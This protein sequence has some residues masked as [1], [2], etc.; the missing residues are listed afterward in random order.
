MA[1][2]TLSFTIEG[3]KQLSRTLLMIADRVKDWTPAFEQAAMDLK[4]IF[5]TEVFE[6]QGA[7]IE[8][9]W[10]G[11]SPNYAAQ[12][13]KRY[14]GRGVLEASGTMRNSFMS[15]VRPDMLGIWNKAEYF[16]YHQSNRPRTKIPRRVM[17]KL[18]NAQKELVVKIFHTYFQQAIVP[19][20]L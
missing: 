16:K 6:T 1:G 18:A 5:S 4:T 19:Q 13:A 3:E 10:Q 2:L 9:H 7:V 8:E 11:L 15:L 14:P 17:I 12:K 20:H